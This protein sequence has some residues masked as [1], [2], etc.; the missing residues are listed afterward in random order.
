[1]KTKTFTFDARYQGKAV[2][3]WGAYHHGIGY[4]SMGEYIEPY[5]EIE[6]VY[7]LSGFQVDYENPIQAGDMDQL[8]YLRISADAAVLGAE[9]AVGM[10]WKD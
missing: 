8:D 1:M 9:I 2:K 10:G 3:V 4:T 5:T 6:R 7:P